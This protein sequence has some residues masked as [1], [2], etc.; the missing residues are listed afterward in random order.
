VLRGEMSLVGPR[1]P[2]VSEVRRYSLQDRER[3]LAAPGLTCIWQV[4]G[5]SEL[6]FEQ[7]VQMDLE[8]LRRP[9]L[10]ADLKLLCRTLPAVILGRGAY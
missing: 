10:L 9:G 4:S 3:L 5:R 2:L 6:S 8:Y 7:Q 1:P